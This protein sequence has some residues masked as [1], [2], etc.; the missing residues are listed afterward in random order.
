MTSTPRAK[1]HNLYFLSVF[2]GRTGSLLGQLSDINAEGVSLLSETPL[3]CPASFLLRI[4]VPQHGQPDLRLE[5]EA[6]SR[7]T[8]KE[9]EAWATG[10]KVGFL[11]DAQRL[12]IEQLVHDFSYA[13]IAEV[14]IPRETATAPPTRGLKGIL[15]SLLPG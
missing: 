4:L 14:K 2:D 9:G 3:Q 12:Q 8:G 1:R 5:F 7:W 13:K 15:K 6:E 10:F 11:T